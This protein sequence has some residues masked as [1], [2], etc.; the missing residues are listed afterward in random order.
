MKKIPAQAYL[1]FAYLLVILA[2]AFL[3]GCADDNDT[4]AEVQENNKPTPPSHRV[5]PVPPAPTDPL[6]ADQEWVIRICT[7][8]VDDR[9]LTSWCWLPAY[10]KLSTLGVPEGSQ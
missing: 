3:F 1:Y 8:A 4:A 10:K 6:P 9:K 7:T 2:A 5:G